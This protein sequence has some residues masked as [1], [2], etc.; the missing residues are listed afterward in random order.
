[1]YHRPAQVIFGV[2]ALVLL[3]S[4]PSQASYILWETQGSYVH[5]M[6]HLLFFGAMLFFIYEIQR[7]ELRGLPGFR[8][9]MWAC[10]LL[11][12]WNLDAVVGHT[13]DW[14]LRSPVILGQGLNRRLLME[15]WHTW[16]Y[17]LTKITHF[18]L[19]LPA[20]Y[21]FYRGLKKLVRQSGADSL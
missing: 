18:L 7:G 21:F 12:W 10:W 9:L 11:A 20:F 3:T 19:P 2:F 16:G 15:N 6:A 17:Y 4:S 13:L 5:Q 14:S 8:S 1:M